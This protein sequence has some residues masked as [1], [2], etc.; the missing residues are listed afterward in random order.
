MTNLFIDLL[1]QEITEKDLNELGSF[2]GEV[3]S[4]KM[5]QP[6]IVGLATIQAY[7]AFKTQT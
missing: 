2:Y 4:I 6:Q 7:I 5:K 1:P 3:L